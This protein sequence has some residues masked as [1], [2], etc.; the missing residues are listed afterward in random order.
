MDIVVFLSEQWLLVSLLVGLVYFYMWNERRRSGQG[1]SIHEATRLIN[2]EA[3]LLVDIRDA[4][5][6]KNGHITDAINLPHTKIKDQLDQ[7]QSAPNQTVLLIDKLGQHVGAIGRDLQHKGF[8]VYRLNGG[9]SE[10]QAQNLPL[11]K[12]GTKKKKG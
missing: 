11:V 3:V 5:E 2:D 10:W 4:N 7:L 9:I 12:A 1:V 8:K 6:Y